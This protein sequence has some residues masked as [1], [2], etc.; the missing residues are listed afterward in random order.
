MTETAKATYL[1]NDGTE[2]GI[3]GGVYPYNI[4]VQY[5]IITN[6]SSD[7]QTTKDGKLNVKIEIDGK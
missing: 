7:A 3:Q 5:P 6:L 1:G 4:K 2:I